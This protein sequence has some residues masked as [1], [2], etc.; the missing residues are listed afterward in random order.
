MRY[1]PEGVAR[2]KAYRADLASRVI[3]GSITEGEANILSAFAMEFETVGATPKR[4]RCPRCK[5][6]HRLVGEAPSFTCPC[7]PD[8]VRSVWDNRA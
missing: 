1:S 6:T 3:Q 4:V 8:T 2:V 7:S 5:R